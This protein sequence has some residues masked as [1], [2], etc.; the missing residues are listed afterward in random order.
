MSEESAHRRRG[1]RLRQRAGGRVRDKRNTGG[2][3]RRADAVEP[4][5]ADG[6]IGVERL[7]GIECLIGIELAAAEGGEQGGQVAGRLGAEQGGERPRHGIQIDDRGRT[8]A[9]GHT[10]CDGG[11]QRGGS[12]AGGAGECDYTPGIHAVRQIVQCR[13]ARLAHGGGRDRLDQVVG[14]SLLEQ[15]AGSG[16]GAVEPDCGAVDSGTGG[17]ASGCGMS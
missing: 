15:C 6:W 11:D 10:A 14:D 4:L 13:H 7:I 8:A 12:A 2:A 1:R 9:G 17:V 5:G 3:R 16:T